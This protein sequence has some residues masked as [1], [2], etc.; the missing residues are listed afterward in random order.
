ML[1]ERRSIPQMGWNRVRL[2]KAH[3]LW[4]DI[5]D[6]T[7][8]YFAN[9]YYA[10]PVDDAV[11]AARTSYGVDFASALARENLFAVQFHPE[12]SQRAGLRLLENFIGWEPG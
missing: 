1:R 3:P 6:E 2:V 11:V 4:D 7:H 9:S 8:F 12:K 10:A 5:D